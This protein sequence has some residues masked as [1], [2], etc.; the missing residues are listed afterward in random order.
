MNSEM[1]SLN[2]AF[3]SLN[4]HIPEYF[5]LDHLRN[6]AQ[7]GNLKLRTV[8]HL[9]FIKHNGRAETKAVIEAIYKEVLK[10]VRELVPKRVAVEVNY[11]R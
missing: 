1:R 9:Q 6:V 10:D 7:Q 11:H 4:K 8:M 2:S 5:D 3:K